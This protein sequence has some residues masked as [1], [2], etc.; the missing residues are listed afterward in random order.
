MQTGSGA[1]PP[2]V[3]SARPLLD[4]QG[5]VLCLHR[6]L[7]APGFLLVLDSILQ[8][9]GPDFVLRGLHTE[10]LSVQQMRIKS[11]PSAEHHLRGTGMREGQQQ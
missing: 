7:L 6:S 2:G 1:V 9:F 3:S 4:A 5:L 11:L 8:P 10:G